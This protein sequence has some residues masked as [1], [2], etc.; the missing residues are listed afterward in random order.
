MAG[1]ARPAAEPTSVVDQPRGG[2]ASPLDIA[3]GL[4]VPDPRLR[5][6]IARAL[7]DD[8][9]AV[10]ASFVA[11]EELAAE[12]VG[13]QPDAVVLGGKASGSERAKDILRLREQLPPAVGVVVVS[14]SPGGKGVR[15]ALKAGAR[16]FVFESELT[17]T[18]AVTVR[19]V[20]AGQLSVP[21]ELVREV[22]NPALSFR[23]KQIL[24]MVVLGFQNQEISVKL[25]L[26]ESTV[27]SHLSSAFRKLGVSSRHEAAALI[28]DPR[29]GLGAGVLSIPEAERSK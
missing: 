20:C 5:K 29:E 12:S 25:H 27:K 14:S 9:I 3:V 21:Q 18:L 11:A 13:R 19:A 10:T 2:A 23:E 15:K 8:G 22:H 28:L 4:A 7:T 26:T 16:G 17:S 6:T 24:G 1:S